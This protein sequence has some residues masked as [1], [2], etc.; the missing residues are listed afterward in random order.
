[1]DALTDQIG[2][3]IGEILGNP[4]VQLLIAGTLAYLALLWL[5]TAWW[6]FSDLRRRT[7]EPA[8][9]YLAAAGV[10]IASPI[11]FPLAV[12]VYRIVRPG[13]TIAEARERELTERL[14]ALEA[15][16]TLACPSC[17]RLVDETWLVCPNCRAR[18]AHRCA[19]CGQTVGLDWALCAW[20]GHE[21]GRTVL[22]ERMPRPVREAAGRQ[23][24]AERD[25]DRER[26]EQPAPRALEPGA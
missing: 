18:L 6:V 10:L 3:V 15:E 19:N 8:L 21:F 9:P 16:T 7:A 23:Q 13:E 1:M 17:N 20:C 25:R 11:L 14:D 22:P 4:I 12:I 26:G 5:A 2:A 24:R